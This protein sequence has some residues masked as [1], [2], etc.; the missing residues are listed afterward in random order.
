MVSYTGLPW[1][2][3]TREAHERG[4][5]QRRPMFSAVEPD[6][7]RDNDGGFTPV[8]TIVWATGFRA[9]LQHLEPMRLRNQLGAITMH[10]TQVAGEPRVHL[11][12]YATS[13]STVG[14]NRAGREAV[15]AIVRQSRL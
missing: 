10:G 13:Q 11:I 7:V 12:G 5:L 9:A 15:A 14:A 4:V 2:R 1:N 6:G 8:D 3:Y